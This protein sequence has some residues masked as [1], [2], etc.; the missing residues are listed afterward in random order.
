MAFTGVRPW[1][2]REIE[3]TPVD[4][5]RGIRALLQERAQI[6]MREARPG[7]TVCRTIAVTSGKGGVGKSVLAVNLAVAMSGLGRK[8]CLLDGNPG[9]GNIELLC[10]LNSYWNL[11]HVIAGSR[12]LEDVCIVG[13]R[14]M[15][16]IPGAS[17]LDELDNCPDEVQTDLLHKLQRLEHDYDI[18]IVDTGSGGHRLVR[19]LAFAANDVLIVTTPEPTAIADAY[20]TIKAINAPDGPDLSVVVNQAND[21]LSGQIIDRIR[22]TART[23]LQAGLAF[24]IGIPADPAVQRSVL[25]R[26]PFIMGAPDCRASQVVRRLA[27]K[28]SQQPSVGLRESYFERLWQRL[29][30]R[31]A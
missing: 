6:R 8:V 5:A 1:T 15:R 26:T 7:A 17:G 19:Q 30:K 3:A 11:S 14:G 13:P 23:F 20:A 4:Q 24:G 16:I 25:T 9:V 31:A 29:H 12:Q 27:E 28:L 2:P 10:G 22:V 18:L 21:E